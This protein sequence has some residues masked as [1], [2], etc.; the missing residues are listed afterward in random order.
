MTFETIL[1][2][3]KGR[4]CN[5]RGDD[6]ALIYSLIYLLFEFVILISGFAKLVYFEKHYLF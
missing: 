6:Y 3:K 2:K 4:I 5:Y 1:L